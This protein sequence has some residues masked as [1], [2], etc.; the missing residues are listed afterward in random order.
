MSDE[1][2]E[3][4]AETRDRGEDRAVWERRR[5][6]F[7]G[8]AQS[9]DDFRP[10]YPT[11]AVTWALGNP[12]E[13]ARLDVVDLGAGTGR[14]SGVLDG[15]G[16]RVTAVEPDPAMRAVAARTLPVRVVAGSAEDTG[17]PGACADAV[18]VGQAFH[19]FDTGRALPEIARVLRPRGS[20]G[21]IW[22]ARDDRVPWVKEFCDIVSPGDR[23]NT[24]KRLE[25]GRG[26]DFGPLEHR[27]FEHVQVLDLAGLL[28]LVGTFSYV[29]LGEHR[30]HIEERVR[31]L[32]ANHPDLR[33]SRSF[34]L[35]YVTEVYRA[36]TRSA[37]TPG[38]DRPG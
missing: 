10:G 7:G 20:L 16:H 35:A 15:L 12:A 30:Q 32:A 27:T 29:R 5:L 17:L 28:G 3:S 36:L 19:W 22:N 11:E 13:G 37:R 34:P 31:E 18:L 4:G 9:Y 33:G 14:L 2:V 38:E 1:P 8:W 24:E 21:V 26:T 23:F 6:S 25:L